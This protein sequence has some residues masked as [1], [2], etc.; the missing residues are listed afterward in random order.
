MPLELLPELL[1]GV[2]SSLRVMC[3]RSS[4]P[5]S[6]S[7]AGVAGLSPPEEV[8]PV[9]EEALS[10]L[11]DEA[12]VVA[13]GVVALPGGAVPEESEREPLKWGLSGSALE[14]IAGKLLEG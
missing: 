7:T 13:A 3:G 12:G 10:L 2:E 4:S 5:V 11:P 9:S 8:L 1:A 6:T 14:T